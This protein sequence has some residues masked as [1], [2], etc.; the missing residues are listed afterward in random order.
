M[1][2]ILH[3]W[4]VFLGEFLDTTANTWR[5][6]ESIFDILKIGL[7]TTI[8]LIANV[9]EIGQ[10]LLGDT[11]IAFPLFNGLMVVA[12]VYAIAAKTTKHPQEDGSQI[13]ADL[14]TSVGAYYRYPQQIR[15]TAKVCVP[16]LGVLLLFNLWRVLPNAVRGI[17]K[18]QGYVCFTDYGQPAAGAIVEIL[19]GSGHHVSVM[20]ERT[21][22]EGFF[23]ADIEKWAQ[24]P[25]KIVIS[26]LQCKQEFILDHRIEQVSGCAQSP[27]NS[28]LYKGTV[29]IISCKSHVE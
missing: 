19:D 18:V 28:S 8:T 25:R 10:K 23:V 3:S 20:P 2:K 6:K 27:A 17:A 13:I 22:H 9:T 29:W 1:R 26:V 5:S 16:L 15:V 14:S 11:P 7:P 12:S 24:E 4:D 21:D